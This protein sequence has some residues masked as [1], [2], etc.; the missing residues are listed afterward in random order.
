MVVRNWGWWMLL[1]V[2]ISAFLILT[3][4]FGYWQTGQQNPNQQVSTQQLPGGEK[5]VVL[6][7]NKQHHYI[8]TGSIN[9]QAV[10]FLVDTGASHVSVPGHLAD[11]LGLKRGYPISVSTANGVIS[12]YLTRIE[13]LGIGEIVLH[14][15]LANINPAMREDEVLLGMS[16]LR[17]LRFEQQGRQLIFRQ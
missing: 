5:V 10:E 2:W 15:V 8:F 6:T 1:G 16:A 9:G 7:P 3:V 4:V 11:T 12:V 13:Q 17:Q 14:D